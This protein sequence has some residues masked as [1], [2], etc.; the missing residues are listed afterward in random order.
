MT[1][2]SNG[3]ARTEFPTQ[4]PFA[5]FPGR[6]VGGASWR[7]SHSPDGPVT[8]CVE[9]EDGAV[10]VRAWGPGAS[11]V[12]DNARELTG[13]DVLWAPIAHRH[14]K[15][16]ELEK[17]HSGLR[18]MRSISIVETAWRVVL[19]QRVTSKDAHFAKRTILRVFG[20]PAPGGDEVPEGLRLPPSAATLKRLRYFDFHQAKVERSRAEI[21]RRVAARARRIEECRD[22]PISD[23][24]KRLSALQGLGPWSVNAIAAKA[25]GDLDAVPV[26]DYHMPNTVAWVFAGEERGDDARMLELLEPFRPERFRVIQLIEAAHLHA[27]RRGP[28]MPTMKWK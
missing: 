15:V 26:G 18:A 4:G 11:W 22:M 2:A 10:R 13:C 7:A 8:M 19:G 9:H 14:P 16:D 5:G 6:V 12:V 27:P 28:R 23:A 1:V 25:L 20:E 3:D 24:R 21:I 17:K